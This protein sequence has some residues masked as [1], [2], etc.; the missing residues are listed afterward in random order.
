[1]I[2]AIPAPRMKCVAGGC[3]VVLL[4]VAV[5]GKSVT[6]VSTKP[7]IMTRIKAKIS[8]LVKSLKKS[9]KFHNFELLDDG[10]SYKLTAMHLMP[11]CRVDISQKM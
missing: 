11:L 7:T 10:F 9:R 3:G 2:S 5:V 6:A 4:A 8:M 1:M